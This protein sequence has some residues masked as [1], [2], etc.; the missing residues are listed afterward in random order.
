MADKLRFTEQ[1]ELVVAADEL[2]KLGSAEPG[3]LRLL[4]LQDDLLIGAQAQPG[5]RAHPVLYGDLRLLHVAEVMALISSMRKD[6]VLSLLVPHARKSVYFSEG[7]VV[8]ASSTVEDDRLG[9]VLWRKGLLSLDQLAEVHDLVTPERKLG[10]VLVDLEMLSPRQL[11]DGI[12][13][14]VLEI[15]Y[16]TFHF[17]R[18][19]FIFTGRK[20]TLRSSVRLDVDTREVIREGVRRVQELTR[21]EELFPDRHAVPAVRPVVVDVALGEHERQMKQLADGRRSVAELVE[22]S[23]LGE[24][25]ALKAL[26]RLRR[27]GVVDLLGRGAPGAATEG[28]GLPEALRAY[29]DALQF[30]FR[31]L[32][33][34]TGSAERLEDF[35]GNPS[36]AFRA[37][38]RNVG[39][40]PSGRLDVET[41]MRNARRLTAPES[42][43]ERSGRDSALELAQNALRALVDY[44][45]FQAMDLLDE[46]TCDALTRELDRLR[47]RAAGQA[48]GDGG[49]P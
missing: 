23:R 9:E 4:H 11:Y 24:L 28:E 14:Q 25:E 31:E 21:L 17:Q 7:E 2:G 34:R 29:A 43:G 5:L 26:A 6:G 8:Y 15:V 22:A 47:D 20:P 35:L 42:G 27:L 36:P 41:L 32:E 48:E 3:A 33:Q 37:V 10:A 39:F 30:I 44:A 16:S 45:A 13:E 38:F 19:E 12:R 1:G 49:A 46:E 40:E 18:G